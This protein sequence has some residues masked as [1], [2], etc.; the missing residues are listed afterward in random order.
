MNFWANDAQM[1]TAINNVLFTVYTTPTYWD[2]LKEVYSILPYI[3]SLD[4]LHLYYVEQAFYQ[5]VISSYLE[6]TATITRPVIFTLHLD[7]FT[8][9]FANK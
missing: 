7:V 2:A 1:N 9:F 8:S 4:Y 6:S 3:Y 5:M